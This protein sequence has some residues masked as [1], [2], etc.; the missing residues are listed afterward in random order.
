M[1]FLTNRCADLLDPC[2][3]NPCMNGGT[4]LPLVP[5]SGDTELACVCTLLF[6]GA[7]CEF[8]RKFFPFQ[9]VIE[10]LLPS[11]LLGRAFTHY[12]VRTTPSNNCV[13]V[14]PNNSQ[15]FLSRGPLTV[16]LTDYGP[17]II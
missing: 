17:F 3:P 14:C 1:L 16:T 10:L 5:G 2:D 8:S 12:Q 13:M 7:R 11:L 6:G 9:S 4:C 15:P